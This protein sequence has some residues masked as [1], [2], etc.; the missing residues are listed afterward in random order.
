[1]SRLNIEL[2]KKIRERIAAIPESYDQ[3]AWCRNNRAA[4]CGTSA[5]LA[6]EAIICAAP[7]VEEGVKELRHLDK[8]GSDYAIPERAAVL[9]GLEGNV[10]AYF[11]Y[12]D[13]GDGGETIIFDGNANK[14][15]RQFK[16]QFQSGDQAGAAVAYL[17]HIIETG[18]V[19]DWFE[20]KD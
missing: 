19:L 16:K 10:E 13:E 20:F 7:T 4:P 2:F 14:W 8:H 1:M 17:D 5:C 12:N 3:E 6:G 9:L 15:P 18:K 11:E